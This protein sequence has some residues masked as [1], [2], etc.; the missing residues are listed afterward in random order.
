MCA[1]VDG[2]RRNGSSSS[3][4]RDIQLRSRPIPKTMKSGL[5]RGD[6]HDHAHPREE[7][8]GTVAVVDCAKRQGSTSTAWQPKRQWSC[9][10]ATLLQVMMPCTAPSRWSTL[11][12][13]EVAGKVQELQ[14]RHA[15]QIRRIAAGAR[16]IRTLIF[17][18]ACLS[19]YNLT[20]CVTSTT[21]L[22][23]LRAA[24][25]SHRTRRLRHIG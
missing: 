12:D 6:N 18:L 4:H 15:N 2:A 16:G 22:I 25:P 1:S 20:R 17:G 9:V 3:H 13:D 19:D 5:Q 10:L 14:V 8:E 21:G 7:D 24:L 11:G 23:H